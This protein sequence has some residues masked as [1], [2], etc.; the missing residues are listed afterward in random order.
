MQDKYRSG[1]GRLSRRLDVAVLVLVLVFGAFANAAGMIDTVTSWEQTLQLR[2]GLHSR[3]SLVSLFCLLALI[4]VPVIST[5][6]CTLIS[7]LLGKIR[8]RWQELACSFVI[9]FVPLGFSVW[10]AHF[11]YH[12]LL[13]YRT[14]VPVTQRVVRTW[15]FFCSV[16]L[17]GHSYP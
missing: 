5:G 8:V 7:R 17:I 10:L 1:I 6:L 9:T 13:G 12:L 14:I 2:M 16:L 4:V 3:L 11:G 15:G